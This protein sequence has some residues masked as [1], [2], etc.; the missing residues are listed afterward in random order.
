ME[1]DFLEQPERHPLSIGY[2]VQEKKLDEGCYDLLASE[3]RLSSLFAIAKGD[4]K[5]KH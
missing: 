4:I 5:F 2:R 1:F 3:A